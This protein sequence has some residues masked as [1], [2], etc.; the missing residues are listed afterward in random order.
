[1]DANGELGLSLNLMTLEGRGGLNVP[2]TIS[3]RSGIKPDQM[4]SWVGLGWFW[5]PGSITRDPELLHKVSPMEGG[6]NH[7]YG[8]DVF[9]QSGITGQVPD[10]FYVSI[11][12]QQGFQFR[13]SNVNGYASQT[14][15]NYANGNL[16]PTEQNGFRIQ[17]RM[18]PVSVGGISAGIQ[19]TAKHDIQK[20]LLTAPDGT[21]YLF[22]SPTLAY[23][24]T[25]KQ[26]NGTLSILQR[27]IYV[28]TW[29]LVAIF[30]TSYVSDPWQVPAGS[31]DGPWIALSYA[32]PVTYTEGGNWLIPSSS[33]FRQTQYLTGVSS[34]TQT[35]EVVLSDRTDP[36]L[37]IQEGQYSGLYR[38][39]D[40]IRLK[41]GTT[42][43][44]RVAFQ[45]DN[46]AGSFTPKRLVG[47]TA[48]GRLRL[49]GILFYGQGSA[50]EPGYRF[51]YVANPTGRLELNE[52]DNQT[53]CRDDYGYFNRNTDCGNGSQD[54]AN[55]ES[56]AWNLN[57]IL[58]PTGA[59]T[60]IG[61]AADRL[62][63]GLAISGKRDTIR[64]WITN[65]QYYPTQST[66]YNWKQYQGGSRV[67]EIHDYDGNE[68][69][70]YRSFTYGNGWSSGIPPRYFQR[71][72]L[73]SGV[74]TRLTASL[75][76]SITW[77][78]G[79]FRTPRTRSP[80][81]CS[82]FQE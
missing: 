12:G 45:T 30:G 66:Y 28:S 24:D 69:H 25:Y 63:T 80:E 29:R 10:R 75:S 23:V 26:P 33:Y 82:D 16:M 56:W 31:E 60:E 6:T 58:H 44:R 72:I 9:D 50:E 2:V 54:I 39:I 70:T 3:Y 53:E 71:L 15:P 64:Y 18:G 1:M 7:R 76:T 40:E 59:M 35:V 41:H 11:P 8:V 79:F 74:R 73:V 5:D 13:L 48:W 55:N 19:D 78:F 49:S 61:Y 81:T 21:R 42:V 47:Q 27:E 37:N 57:R 4:P 43:L 34:P 14:L 36:L 67:T 32:S 62:Y 46:V 38:K 22:A 65:S 52:P 77:I 17:T 20:I 68:G 51:E